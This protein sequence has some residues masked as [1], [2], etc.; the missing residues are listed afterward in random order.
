[1]QKRDSIFEKYPLHPLLV[2]LFPVTALLA[3]NVYNTPVSYATTPALVSM[4][5]VLVLWGILYLI[6]G[7]YRASALAASWFFV[8]FFSYGYFFMLIQESIRHRYLLGLWGLFFM[9]GVVCAYCFKKYDKKITTIA[10]I[11]AA[12]LVALSLGQI[13]TYKIKMF[14]T[15]P[16]LS[17]HIAAFDYGNVA[18]PKKLPDIYNIIIDAYASEWSFDQFYHYDISG[19]TSYLRDHDFSIVPKSS[20]NYPKTIYSLPSQLNMDYLDQ[21]LGVEESVLVSQD[22]RPNHERL[23]GFVENNRVLRF[24]KDQ[25]Y[26]AVHVGSMVTLT[27]KNRYADENFNYQPAPLGSEFEMILYNTTMLKPISE[28]F[29]FIDWR[30]VQWIRIKREIDEIASIASR[31]EPVYVFAHLEVPHDPYV[32]DADGSYVSES[33]EKTRDIQDNYTRQV[34]YLNGALTKMIGRIL[35]QSETPPIIVLQSDHGSGIMGD[36]TLLAKTGGD[37][38]F[39]LRESMRNFMAILLPGKEHAVLPENLTPVN[40]WRVIFNQ[41]FGTKLPLLPNKNFYQINGVPGLID[42]TEAVRYR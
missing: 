16:P 8:L 20:S 39:H 34:E 37:R 36:Y 7:A 27:Q 26:Y 29:A 40:E 13:A 22:Q 1:M 4:L 17:D 14:F 12:V 25:G 31:P 21:L 42:A 3:A 41:Y 19:F 33:L 10:N 24:L 15:E 30:K 32:F 2:A 35:E 5:G 18:P 6:T 38:D 9:I 23:T 11:M 28:L